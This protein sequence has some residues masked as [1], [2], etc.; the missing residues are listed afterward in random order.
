M[1]GPRGFGKSTIAKR[2]PAILPPINLVEAIPGEFHV[3]GCYES[4]P[5]AVTTVIRVVNAGIHPFRFSGVR[6]GGNTLTRLG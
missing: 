2:L 4:L 5:R 3:T 1:V 6:F